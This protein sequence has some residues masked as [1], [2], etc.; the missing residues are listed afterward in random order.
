M[1][2][3]DLA[4]VDNRGKDNLF[5]MHLYLE[6]VSVTKGVLISCMIQP[7]VRASISMIILPPPLFFP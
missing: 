5:N 6:K 2:I 7:N 1:I 3:N 4:K